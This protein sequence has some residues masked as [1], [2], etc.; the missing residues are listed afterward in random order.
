VSITLSRAVE[1]DTNQLLP[2]CRIRIPWESR[3]KSATR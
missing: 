2:A 3:E 1:V